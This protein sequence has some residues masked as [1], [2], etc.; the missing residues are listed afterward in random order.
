MPRGLLQLTGVSKRFRRGAA[1][2][3]LG[4]LILS[5][6]RRIL[7]RQRRRPVDSFWAVDD[8]SFEARPGE[9]VGLIGPNG[10]GKSTALKLIARILRPDRG[11]VDVRGRLTAL[12][13]ISAGF[14]GDLT[15][16]EN[17]YMNAS[18]LGMRKA[19][20]E[21]KLDAI[22]DFS[23]VE[24]FIDTP[25]K[26]YSAGMQA[27][28]GFSVAAHVDPDVLLVDEVLA[29]GDVLFRQRCIGRMREL[30]AGGAVLL[31]VTHNLEQMQS[32]CSRAVVL[33]RGRAVFDG[34]P[35][36]AVAHYFDALRAQLP[37][38]TSS[39]DPSADAVVALVVKSVEGCAA[40]VVSSEDP[41]EIDVVL[42]AARVYRRLAI[43]I[44]IRRELGSCLANFSSIRDDQTFAVPSGRS[45]VT[46]SL[47]SLPLGGG[48]YVLSA[49]L[50]DAESGRV[51][52]DSGFRYQLFVEDG[53]R[54]TGILC[55]PHEWC[56]TDANA[57][58]ESQRD[59][60]AS[61]PSP[62]VLIG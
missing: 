51:I 7:G 45:C 44:D 25:V 33:D 55:L 28:L 38:D 49:L 32:F 50:R 60:R 46:L 40:S 36:S 14:H 9:A 16:R 1:H 57:L 62:G 35:N 41:I 18:I 17:I 56:Y 47:P 39:N 48:A 13:E 59:D 53:G 54:P 10:A 20:I 34:L 27:R 37:A 26:R 8:L 23:G 29:V 15:G 22:I 21:R 19:E 24:P 52:A 2:D 5:G 12:I 6:C 61:R 30:V 4:E 42:R 3:R 31:F 11:R 58:R 43:E